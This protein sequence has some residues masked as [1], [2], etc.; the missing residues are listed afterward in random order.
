MSSA[1]AARTCT[2]EFSRK[3]PTTPIPR[4]GDER[5]AAD[6]EERAVVE[7]IVGRRGSLRSVLGQ[8]EAVAAT[9]LTVLI[10]GETGTGREVIA[11]ALHELS[12]R[13]TRNLVTV[14]CAA[15]PAGLLESELFG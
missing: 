8:V 15:M 9:N 11:R 12:P 1:A 14:N 5:R 13:R 6:G 7:K 2:E 4:Q 3:M 10:T